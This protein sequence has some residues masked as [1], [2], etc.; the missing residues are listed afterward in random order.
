MVSAQ[1]E[2]FMAE[3]D[4]RIVAHNGTTKPTIHSVRPLRTD[5]LSVTGIM[6][7]EEVVPK[8]MK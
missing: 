1:A 8:A 7:D 6:A 2:I 4:M 3:P 5:W